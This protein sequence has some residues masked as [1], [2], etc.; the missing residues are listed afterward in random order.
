MQ[1]A[2]PILAADIGGTRA[3][4]RSGDGT[5]ELQTRDHAGIKALLTAALRDLGI[6]GEGLTAVLALA[7][8]VQGDHASIT[9]LSWDCD[10]EALRRRFGLR[11]LVFMNDL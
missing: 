5:L 2:S 11:H 10:G 9:N 1:S 4:F 6:P 3:R 8:P 7:G